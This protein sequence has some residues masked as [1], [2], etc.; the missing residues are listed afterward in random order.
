ML[1]TKLLLSI[2]TLFAVIAISTPGVA[3]KARFNQFIGFGDSTLDSGYFRYN[4]SGNATL[5]AQV[6]A[7]V[8]NGANGGFAGPGVMYSTM[9]AGMFG[10]SAAPIG[11]GGTNY[12]V[13][14]SYTT[15]ASPG[16]VSATQQITNYLASTG[17]IANPDAL[18]VVQ[19]GNNDLI[20]VTNQGTAWIAAN[21][22][23]LHE[24]ALALAASVATLQAAGARNIVVPNTFYTAALTGPGGVVPASNADAYARAVAFSADRWATLAAAGVRFIPADLTTLFQF[25]VQHPT[26][27]G[28][29]AASV[30]AA[31]APSPVA[32]VVTTWANITPEQMQTYLFIDGKHL[33]TAGQQIEADY[34]YSLISAPTQISLLAES[35]IQNG[36]ARM[37]T[38]QG[39]IDLSGQHRG[40]TGINFW[41]TVGG[42]S[43]N[44]T[45]ETGFPDTSG[46]RFVGSAGADYLTPCGIVVGA[47]FTAGKQTQ[48]FSS[49]GGHYDQVEEVLSLYTAYKAG[50]FWGNVVASYGLNQ[51]EIR[52]QVVLG[53]FLD[54]NSADTNGQ[55]LALALRAGGDIK[56]GP[57]TTGPVG[58]LVV[59]QVR[60]KGFTE[61]GTSGVT[62]LTF[63]GQT[64]DSVVSQL[65]WRVLLDIGDWQPFVE[66]KWNHECVEQKRMVRAS[67][68]TVSAPTYSVEAA[69]APTDW[70]TASIGSS[71]KLNERVMLRGVASAVLSDPQV[72]KSYGGELGISVNF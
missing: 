42:S 5:D 46:G 32:A 37:A 44:F 47:A 69:P 50:P 9:L 64:R 51:N 33:T 34:E 57:L 61:T 54:Q 68:T 14:A 28:F 67:L 25:V 3:K 35:A 13:G 49:N 62:A 22:N 15:M 10:L 56:L 41:T 18:Y 59:Q 52:R 20:Y 36:L 11:D 21:P 24:Q 12:A 48:D 8:A 45:T 39:Q 43:Q 70:T 65:G 6:A 17:G 29:S 53:R 31:N 66:A 16:L 27:F 2:A 30:L 58:G 55:S 7:A 71:Y 26:L 4:A 72:V 1:K 60:I 23:Y 38:I 63:G 19:T 40:P